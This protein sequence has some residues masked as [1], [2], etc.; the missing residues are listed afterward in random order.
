MSGT[1]SPNTLWTAELKQTVSQ[2]PLALGDLLLVAS[3]PSGS[4]M[5]QHGLVSAVSLADGTL[6]WQKTFEYSL[7]SGLAAHHW[8]EQDVVIITSSSSDFLKGQGNLLAL[9]TA[10]E[11]VWRWPGEEEHFSAPTMLADTAVVVAGGRTLVLADLQGGEQHIPLSVQASL[12]APLVVNHVAY[13]SCRSADLLAMGLTGEEQW[14]FTFAGDKQ[15]WLDKTPVIAGAHIIATSS[16][17]SIYVLE[18]ATGQL[19]WH[20][21]PDEGRNASPPATDGEHLYVGGKQGVIALAVGNG[22]THWTFTTSRPVLA[23]PLVLRDH[24]LVTSEDHKFYLLDKKSG[25]EQWH[26]ELP[27][28]I[29]MPPL[30]TETAILVADRGGNVVAL[31][32]PAEVTAEPAAEPVVDP[33]VRRELRWQAA[34]RFEQEK[35]FQIAAELW[36]ELGELERAA[37]QYEAGEDW[38]SAAKLWRQLDRYGKRAEA[39]KRHAQSLSQ[40]TD[41]EKA[42]AWENAS[43]VFAEMGEKAERDAAKREVARY[44][45]LPIL[46]VE[47]E[48]EEM[49]KNAWAKIQ[50]TV[51]NEGFGTAQ[52][53]TVQLKDDRF[54]GQMSATQT[55]VTVAAGREATGRLEVRP[56]HQG[57]SVPMQINIE[58]IDKSG[59]QKL[60]HI[61][62]L[63]VSGEGTQ[64]VTRPLDTGAYGS[65]GSREALA[66]LPAPEGVDLVELRSKLMQYFSRE[67]LSDVLFE[68]GI[69]EENFSDRLNIMA[70]ELITALARNGRIE[71][72]ITICERDR[73]HV[74]WRDG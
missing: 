29:E 3:R 72:L 46:N 52:Y 9:N 74:A 19:V 63:P 27:R 65:T 7:I 61:F 13:I 45:G 66:R 35:Q 39:L 41:A 25:T 21:V 5:A 70:R 16:R 24:V 43:R 71:E 67:E 53:M 54:E 40:A 28:R 47:I 48:A 50:Y 57:S 34:E 38:L 26:F 44:R 58:Y 1:N 62:Y 36:H 2:P 30:L 37:V 8:R 20:E 59:L 51:R 49:I 4:T 32:R 6:R 69:S 31:P 22:R 23:K 18:Q 64:V 15:D 11:E 12:S 33:A 68:L 42:A 10:G 56:R 14:H 73:S 55:M 17:G 60:E